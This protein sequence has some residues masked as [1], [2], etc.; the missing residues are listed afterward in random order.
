[1]T[2]ADSPAYLIPVP[3]ARISVAADPHSPI[4]QVLTG[5]SILFITSIIAA[6]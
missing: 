4:A 6:P 1:M 2:I 3:A 5:A